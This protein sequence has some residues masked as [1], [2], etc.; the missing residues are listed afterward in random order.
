MRLPLFPLQ[1][2]F[3][4]GERIPLHIFEARYLQLVHDCKKEAISFGIPVYLNKLMPFGVE[5]VLE[6][7]VKL[8]SNGEIDV[9]CRAKKVIKVVTFEKNMG[10]KLYSGGV[11]SVI[12]NIKDGELAVKINV[13]NKIQVLYELMGIPSVQTLAEEFDSFTLAHRI[14][15]SKLQ[16][17]ELLQMP[18]E[19]DRL[20]FIETHLNDL[21]KVLKEVGRTKEII[22]FNGHFKN[23]DPLDF[24]DFKF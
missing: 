3:F 20:Y 14:G 10:S 1:S 8:Y 4:P 9:V 15:F 13:I 24:N 7:I 16:E 18:K 2:I 17:Y 22:E 21:I 19:S 23:F 6:E 11:V 12:E 5:V